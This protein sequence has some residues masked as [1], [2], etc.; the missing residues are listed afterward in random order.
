MFDGVPK[1][2]VSE[3]GTARLPA[4]VIWYVHVTAVPIERIW[5]GAVLPS[6]SAVG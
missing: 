1:S 4:F 3:T 2:S 5:P 6:S